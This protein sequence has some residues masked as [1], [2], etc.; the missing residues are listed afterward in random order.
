[1]P[2]HRPFL[3]RF[4]LASRLRRW[5]KVLS[6]YGLI[7][8][9]IFIAL[10][11]CALYLLRSNMVNASH[12]VGLQLAQRISA[13]TIAAYQQEKEFVQLLSI[14][15]ADRLTHLQQ[16]ALPAAQINEQ[17]LAFID[18]A[19]PR[20]AA[21]FPQLKLTL[22]AMYAG[23]I[24]AR[25]TPQENNYD[26]TKQVW[27]QQALQHP[28]EA[29]VIEPYRDLR[30][31]SMVV[32]IVTAKPELNF[33]LGCDIYTEFSSEQTLSSALPPG[34]NAFITD[35]QGNV[36]FNQSAID[37]KPLTS[38][39]VQAYGQELFKAIAHH[40]KESSHLPNGDT[41]RQCHMFALQGS[42]TL[43]DHMVYYCQERDANW[44][45]II[46][47]PQEE[48]LLNFNHVVLIFLALI[49]C[50]S[51]MEGLM[52]WRSWRMARQLETNTEALKVLANS[53]QDI[54][55]V[56]IQNG[57]FSLLRSRSYFRE[58]LGQKQNYADFMQTMQRII[59]PEHWPAFAREYS[60]QNLEYLATHHI[61]DLGHDVLLTENSSGRYVWFN[62]R[63]LFDESLDLNESII[64]FKQIDSEKSKAI[65]E[66]QLL[67]D[68][69]A[70]AQR[71]EKAKNTFFAN[72]SHDMRSPLS[73]I[74]GLCQLANAQSGN[75]PYLMQIVS[76]I[77]L[78]ARQ[79]LLLVDDILEVSRPDMTES[80]NQEIFN[81]P[82]FL[83]NN[84][85]VF[86]LMA[87]QNERTFKLEYH[88]THQQVI[89]D[90]HKLQQ[91]LSNLLSNAFKYSHAGATISC[92]VQEVPG[93][94]KAC[95]FIFEVSDNGIG[96]QED[97]IVK[98]FEPYAREQRLPG[99]GG[100]GLG[101]SIVH[102]LVSLM[103]GNI[104][105][106]S[107]PDVGTT[108]TIT[109][110]FGLPKSTAL[111]TSAASD[112]APIQVLAGLH[113]LLAEDTKLNQ[114]LARELLEQRG[115]HVQVASNGQEALELFKASKP[116][117][118]DVILLDMRMPVMD[119]CATACAIR[120]LDR[121]D[122]TEVPIIAITA[123]AFAEDIAATHAA[124]MDAHIAKPLDFA[125]LEKTVASLRAR[126]HTVATK[127]GEQ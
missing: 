25:A 96:M 90:S 74:L 73:G 77:N 30:T 3:T 86:R 32:T 4:S 52:L 75:A 7:L 16:R 39:Q 54:V 95:Q 94:S 79:L 31:G 55:R 68:A 76:K 63:I 126:H 122:A 45:T 14:Y 60:L 125:L 2:H 118:I 101:L 5:R 103:G 43:G 81:L 121:A 28:G 10:S 59:S 92:S 105:V 120:Q 84:L 127:E 70:L 18:S 49:L 13:S 98:L 35:K 114:D 115:A 110:P 65:E 69:L 97:F 83:D 112:L 89:G 119:G 66:H 44:L 87:A 99:V 82:A 56:N 107:K 102:H 20:F 116:Y 93:P 57:T 106:K 104:Q 80:L 113:I 33:A 78:S 46:T 8:F 36:I 61:R 50:F 11:G 108:F 124:G 38:I 111:T 1:M 27:Y 23:K 42:V 123:N 117:Q 41:K 17:L 9:V 19:Q 88:L 48:L 12:Q 62:V 24:V 100:T 21:A 6:G 72:M 71:N 91:I 40:L 29:V 47:A 51:V 37:T 22:F 109:L 26:P 64:S 58:L 53:F 15:A 85:E 34:F 67:K